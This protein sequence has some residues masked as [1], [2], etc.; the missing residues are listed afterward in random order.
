MDF[1]VKGVLGALIAIGIHY[2]IMG[3]H[4]FLAG[5]LASAPVFAAFAHATFAHAGRIDD[6]HASIQ[7]HLLS[8]IPTALYLLLLL[9]LSVRLN[10]WVALLLASIGWMAL[11]L[12]L[13]VS[14][15]KGS[16]FVA[17][18]LLTR[19]L[20]PGFALSKLAALWLLVSKKPTRFASVAVLTIAIFT[21]CFGYLITA[22]LH[23]KSARL[24]GDEQACA[25]LK[26]T[27]ALGPGQGNANP[28]QHS[29]LVHYV[30]LTKTSR[31]EGNQSQAALYS[32]R[33]RDVL[34][35]TWV[36]G[37]ASRPKFC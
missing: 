21:A 15:L 30:S 23:D 17:N 22:P 24:P 35:G 18:L 28:I 20:V 4:S 12:A 7:F 27:L 5:L 9:W 8:M 19:L 6:L 33:A 2:V 34:V 36:D 37:T 16:Y 31:L 26:A 1:V 11:S 14:W 3:K 25:L 13:I 32:K 10:V 29:V